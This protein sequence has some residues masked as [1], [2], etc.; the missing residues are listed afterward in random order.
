MMW[1][2]L[3]NLA[4]DVNTILDNADGITT[5]P[6]IADDAITL[7]DN[8]DNVTHHLTWWYW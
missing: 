5:L 3:F 6:D 1:P 2:P 8:A 7:S 4:D